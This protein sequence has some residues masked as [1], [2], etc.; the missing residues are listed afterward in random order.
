MEVPRPGVKSELQMPA[1]SHS[2]SKDCLIC[3]LHHSSWQCR[4]LN[5]LSKARGGTWILMDTSHFRNQ[6]S[7]NGNSRGSFNPLC[8]ARDWTQYK[9]VSDPSCSRIL[10]SLCHIGNSQNCSFWVHFNGEEVVTEFLKWRLFGWIPLSSR[11][12]PSG[13]AWKNLEFIFKYPAVVFLKAGPQSQRVGTGLHWVFKQRELEWFL[14]LFTACVWRR[15][16]TLLFQHFVG[17]PVLTWWLGGGLCFPVN[18]RESALCE[19]RGYFEVG[20]IACCEQE[21]MFPPSQQPPPHP[22][23]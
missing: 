4:I 8:W 16:S 12:F 7:Q 1:Y 3:D 13:W 20:R 10:N 9:T 14:L 22:F 2:H 11:T 19:G 21:Q 5:P 15:S 17:S 23:P 6:P 18:I